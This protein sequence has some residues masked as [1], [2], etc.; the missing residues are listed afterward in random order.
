MFIIKHSSNISEL[1]EKL[2]L[3]LFEFLD[4]VP[5]FVVGSLRG[6]GDKRKNTDI[7]VLI[8]DSRSSWLFR[9]FSLFVSEGNTVLLDA[10]RGRGDRGIQ[11]EEKKQ[12]LMRVGP[13]N[14]KDLINEREVR[15]VEVIWGFSRKFLWRGL[16]LIVVSGKTKPPR[17]C[18]FTFFF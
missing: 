1:Y 16:V 12:R 14:V 4:W 9:P 2:V 10:T 8:V 3:I 5:N 18:W 11:G 17:E 7:D 13:D 15:G 6:R